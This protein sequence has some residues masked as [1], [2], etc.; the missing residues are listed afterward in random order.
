MLK[1]EAWADREHKDASRICEVVSQVLWKFS[2]SALLQFSNSASGGEVN[3]RNEL[4][5]DRVRQPSTLRRLICP[6]ASSPQ[7]SMAA[8]SPR[9]STVC[10]LMRLLNSSLSRSMPFVVPALFHWEGGSA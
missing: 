8:V 5:F 10:V 4:S 7:N 2:D 1:P 9:G 6:E 3:R